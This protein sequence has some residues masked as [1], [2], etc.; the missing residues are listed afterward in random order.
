MANSKFGGVREARKG[1]KETM[2]GRRP[3]KWKWVMR[4]GKDGV[5]HAKTATQNSSQAATV[6]RS[7]LGINK[8]SSSPPSVHE[9]SFRTTRKATLLVLRST[10]SP[11]H[12]ALG[13]SY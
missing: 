4:F 10:S 11:G 1:T 13:A 7:T 9:L 2:K 6:K 5:K 8:S 12:R 3:S